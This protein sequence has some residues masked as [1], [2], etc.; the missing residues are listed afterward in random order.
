MSQ[1]SSVC[2]FSAPQLTIHLNFLHSKFF[3]CLDKVFDLF[4][5]LNLV[6]RQNSGI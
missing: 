5:L 1:A 3:D 4:Y 6:F 2:I